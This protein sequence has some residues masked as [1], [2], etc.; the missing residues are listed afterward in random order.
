M[1]SDLE[2]KLADDLKTAARGKLPE[3][4]TL[5]LLAAALQNETIAR[6]VQSEG[7][8]EAT[9]LSVLRRELKKRQ[10][11]AQLYASGGRSELAQQELNEALVIE[12][13]LPAAPDEAQVRAT[14][15]RLQKE[16]GLAGP[17]GMGQLMKALLAH[18]G[19]AL[20]GQTASRLVRSVLGLG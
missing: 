9:A 11:A 6:R 10:E 19:G 15:E 5:R 7:L 16:L 8:D 4:G 17:T 2:R 14:A 3:L 13:Y 18:Y 20:D 12:R 1:S